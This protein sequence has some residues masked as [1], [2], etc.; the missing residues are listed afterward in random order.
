MLMPKKVKY[1]YRHRGKL[2]GV[3]KRGSEISFGDYAL[4]ALEADWITAN[5]IEAARV[6]INRAMAREGKVYIR[7]FPD[8]PYTKKPLETRMG[9][10]KGALEGWVAVVK[11]GRILFEIGGTSYEIAKEA[12]RLASHKLP[13]KTKLICRAGMEVSS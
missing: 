2:G 10:G 6:A 12:L 11:Q 4:K 3:A 8:Q 1:R 13:V 7:I 5:Q 9:K